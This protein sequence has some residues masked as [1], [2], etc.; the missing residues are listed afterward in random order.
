[1][2]LDAFIKSQE[3][4]IYGVAP[5]DVV[6][7][8]LKKHEKIFEAWVDKGFQADMDWLEQMKEDQSR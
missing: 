3:W 6:R 1:M 5:F 2:E 4:S 8:K 7:E